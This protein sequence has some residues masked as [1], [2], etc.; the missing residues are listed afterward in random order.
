[1]FTKFW[2]GQLWNVRPA[3]RTFQQFFRIIV[4]QMQTFGLNHVS[5]AAALNNFSISCNS[6]A[7]PSRKLNQQLYW[8]FNGVH[9]WNG[10]SFQWQK[11][12]QKLFKYEKASIP[13]WLHAQVPFHHIFRFVQLSAFTRF[14]ITLRQFKTWITEMEKSFDV[15]ESTHKFLPLPSPSRA[16]FFLLCNAFE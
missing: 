1:M 16:L 8:A 14:V 11:H 9:P 7:N 5:R 13:F 2:F 4:V 15:V 12:W 3:Q 6:E 10:K